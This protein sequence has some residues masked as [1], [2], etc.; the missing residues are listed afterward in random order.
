[1][2]G[3][4]GAIRC[5]GMDASG[6]VKTVSDGV[7]LLS[8]RGPDGSGVM[9]RGPVC[10]GHARLSIIDPAGGAQPLADVS[11]Q[12]LLSY[13]GEI[14]NFQELRIELEKLGRRFATKSD[15]EV[16]L[17]AYLEWG[18]QCVRRF[19]GMFS[20]VAVDYLRNTALLA[21]DRLG[22]KPAYYTIQ[23][24]VFWFSS[25]LEPL[26]RLVGPFAMDIQ[27][28][29]DYLY[30]QYVHAPSTIYEDVSQLP[31]AHL[32]EIDLASG[33]SSTSR[34][35]SLS[36]QEDRS[37]SL[38]DWVDRVDVLA[39]DAVKVRLVSDVP[40]GA[41]LSGGIDSSLVV[42]YMAEIMD[43]PVKTF[44]IGFNE[45][46]YSELQYAE[47]VAKINGTEH[48]VEIVEADSLG[49]L[50]QL[51]RHH[52][53]PFADSSAIPTHHVSRLARKHVTMVLSGDGGDENFAGY[54]SYEHIMRSMYPVLGAR[55]K[56]FKAKARHLAFYFF[57]RWQR[58]S[59]SQL[60]LV[61]KLHCQTALHFAPNERRQLFNGQYQAV[62]RDQVLPRRAL[63]DIG[64]A[65]LISRL[66]NL[67]L[68]AYLPFDILTK[69]DIASMTNSLEARV[70]L[71]DHV[72]VEA[73]ATIPAEFKF[74]EEKY[75]DAIEYEKKYVLKLLAKRRYPASIIDRPKMGF[76]VPLGPWFAG[77]LNNEVR[78][79][80]LK[81]EF[82]VRYFDAG[83]IRNLVE[84]H[85][86]TNNLQAKLWNLLFLEEWMRT[87]ENALQAA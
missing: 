46:D 6:L 26:Y 65:P 38:Q 84:S 58:L 59:M 78:R 51:V 27:A 85:T 52:G 42:G 83:Y 29:D 76:G 9:S 12:G 70:P 44:S 73:A 40:F 48:H 53:Q 86:E 4:F 49:L 81:S 56:G 63:L 19:R 11:G 14:Y 74:R 87:H 28:L 57:R 60:D 72:L 64:N 7:S 21:R 31:P 32:V 50:P 36:F 47:Q 25:E 37:L 69:V 5:D 41:F 77:K 20:F 35:W 80:L 13:N 16:V 15:T 43:Q 1:M 2:C 39:R 33:K 79:R 61:Y 24:G 23:N 45:A 75:K 10:L 55:P 34:Y 22:I 18:A 54:N 17:N 67:D 66:Q 8:H 68:M 82:L 3:I 30:W 62:V 71:L